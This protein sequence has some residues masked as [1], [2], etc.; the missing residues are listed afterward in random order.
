[1]R[2]VSPSLRRT[3]LLTFRV[4]KTG[5]SMPPMIR[6]SSW[7]LGIAR[8]KILDQFRKRGDRSFEDVDERLASCTPAS[9][10]DAL[11]G[12]QDAGAVHECMGRLPAAQREAVHLAFFQDLAYPEIARVMDC[13]E[14]TVKTRVFHAKRALKQC[15]ELLR[16]GGAHA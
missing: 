7:V 10:A 4:P 12:V 2:W 9:A 14:G 13:P 3:T 15:L 5:S 6:V 16:G 1:M 11:A 8:H